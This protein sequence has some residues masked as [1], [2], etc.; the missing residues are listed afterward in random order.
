MSVRTVWDRVLGVV[1]DAE[2]DAVLLVVDHGLF[3]VLDLW[4]LAAVHEGIDVV[5]GEVGSGIAELDKGGGDEA[6]TAKPSDGLG[7]E[8][9][10]IGLGDDGDGITC[11]GIKL[12]GTLCEK[13]VEDDGVEY[14]CLWGPWGDEGTGGTGDMGGADAGG[15]DERGGGKGRERLTERG[16]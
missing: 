3:P 10:A 9:L 12:V 11:L 14:A 7:N 8:P 15:G 5:D 6:R 16:C 2:G 1:D 13:I 4:E